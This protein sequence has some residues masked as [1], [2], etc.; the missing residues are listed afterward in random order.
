[1]PSIPRP[2]ASDDADD[3]TF[4]EYD[5]FRPDHLPVPGPFLQGADVLTGADHCAFHRLTRDIFEER[6]VYDATFGYNL[7]RLNLD[8]RHPDAGWRYARVEADR[9][10]GDG[11]E[12]G[13]EGDADVL[14]AEFTPTTKFCPQSESLTIGAFRAWNGLSDRH[15]YE[16]VS[17]GLA[18]MH[19]ESTDI[20]EKL[21]SLEGRLDDGESVA[22]SEDTPRTGGRNRGRS[23]DADDSSLPF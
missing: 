21:R 13:D 23:D 7:A 10:G 17:V 22:D 19:H 2:F 1:M 4:D 5:E 11:E 6:G 14:L 15:D 12:G 18:P 16:R 20:N 8:S 3:E 9:E